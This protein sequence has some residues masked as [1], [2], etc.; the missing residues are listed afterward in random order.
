MKSIS[1]SYGVPG[2]RLGILASAK[3]DLIGELKHTVAIWNINSFAEF[4]MQIA[5]KYSGDYKKAM[6]DFQTVRRQFIDALQQIE[7][8]QAYPTQANFV[9]CEIGNGL[10]AAQITKELLVEHN[11]FIKDLTAK[12]GNGKQYIRLA[13]RRREENE[14]LIKALK[15]ILTQS[16]S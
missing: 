5:E 15:G 6:N 1:K 2:L 16:D 11:L 7:G 10:L 9:M 13:V 3:T 14:V 4:F 8:L 12:I